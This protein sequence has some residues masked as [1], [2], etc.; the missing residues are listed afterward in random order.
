MLLAYTSPGFQRPL[1]KTRKYLRQH[2]FFPRFAQKPEFSVV[3]RSGTKRTDRPLRFQKGSDVRAISGSGPGVLNPL[4]R[5][6][7]P[8][9]HQTSDRMMG[10][11]EF[12]GE[13]T[14]RLRLSVVKGD[15]SDAMPRH[16]SDFDGRNQLAAGFAGSNSSSKSP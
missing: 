15:V 12:R 8:L 3:K 9:P 4:V 6:G 1:Q 11:I 14:G 7:R 2:A 5:E 16:H 13:M 10:G